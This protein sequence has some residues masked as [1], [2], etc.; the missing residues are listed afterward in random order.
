ME[1]VLTIIKKARTAQIATVDQSGTTIKPRVRTFEVW[2][3]DES[4][5]YFQTT[6][7]KA[8]TAQ[9]VANPNIEVHVFIPNAENPMDF[10]MLRIEGIAEILEGNE[11]I[12]KAYTDRPW[13]KD[14]GDQME[15]MGVNGNL[16]IFRLAHGN[17]RIFDMSYNCRESQIPV[18][19]F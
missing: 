10:K 17:A 18:I 11:W 7:I 14:I 8:N 12:E 13:L 15:S 3:A 16:F 4:G 1:N 19:K 6:D 2:F 5:I 9:I